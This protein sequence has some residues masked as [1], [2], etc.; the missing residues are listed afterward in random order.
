MTTIIIPLFNLSWLTIRFRVGTINN[1]TKK[2]R[3]IQKRTKFFAE[4]KFHKPKMKKIKH[5]KIIWDFSSCC[6]WWVSLAKVL[7]SWLQQWLRKT[8]SRLSFAQTGIRKKS[9][10]AHTLKK[11][12]K[13]R[14]LKTFPQA[15][16]R[17]RE[18]KW[19]T[20]T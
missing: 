9:H 20:F 11:Q 15:Q 6:R 2:Q 18:E 7:A 8:D 17:L 1:N 19:K 13:L 3:L 5:K 4:E 10:L 16:Y 12:L 14:D